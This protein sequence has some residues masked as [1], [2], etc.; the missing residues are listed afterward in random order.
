MKNIQRTPE[1]VTQKN[2]ETE[3]KV[4]ERQR[5]IDINT[6]ENRDKERIK[7][8]RETRRKISDEAEEKS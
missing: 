8:K 5:G 4:R 7:K 1:K 6:E 3:K 2:K